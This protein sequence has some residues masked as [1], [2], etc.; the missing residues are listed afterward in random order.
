[1]IKSNNHQV[2]L[3]CLLPCCDQASLVSPLIDISF[4]SADPLLATNICSGRPSDCIISLLQ[5][6]ECSWRL[7]ILSLMK[8]VSPR[9][10]SPTFH[11]KQVSCR[12]RALP[13]S[14]LWKTS[15]VDTPQS[16]TSNRWRI[17]CIKFIII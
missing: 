16:K 10:S 1:V 14:S 4:P 9:R 7:L 2:W 11:I 12:Y 5:R 3:H 6:L 17:I 13:P 8:V 15:S